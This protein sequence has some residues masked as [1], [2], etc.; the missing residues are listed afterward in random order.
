M[1]LI[2]NPSCNDSTLVPYVPTSQNPWDISK[3]NHVYRRLGF[4]AIQSDIDAALGLTPD[5]FIDNLVDTAISL[6]VTAEPFWGHFSVNDFVDFE[7]ENNQYI[8]E[9]RIQTGNDIIDHGL[10]GKLAFFWMNHFVTELEAYNYSPYMYQYY[11]LMQTYALGNI[12]DFTEAIGINPAMLIYLNGFEN[13]NINPNENYARELYELFTLGE[14]IGYTQ[15][16][17]LETA[18]ALTGYN[19]W[20]EVG[21]EIYFDA[22]TFDAGVKTI[23]G[24]TGSWGYSD[25]IHILFQER[26]TEIARHFCTKLYTFFVSPSVDAIIETNVIQP[27]AQTLINNNFELVPILKQLFKSEHFFDER[28]RGV[29]IKSPYDLMFS[30]SKETGF[31][32]NDDIMDAFV[33]YGALMGQ[34]MYNPL[35]VAGWQRDESWIN[36]STLTGR[37]QLLELYLSYLYESGYEFTLVDLAR[38]LSN[39]SIDPYYITQ[40]MIDRFMSKALYTIED[41]NIA[42]DIFKWDIPQNYYDEGLWN[43]SWSTAP[44]QC[45]LLLKHI[46]TIPEFQLK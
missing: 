22:S 35:D 33:Y 3:V 30:F 31:F 45:F 2:A 42:T 17:I 44:Y 15:D 1:T 12:K 34:E 24:Q 38:D 16:D 20:I 13:T 39:D 4:G 18:R 6:P 7:T 19:H 8:M 23:F 28:A 5:E 14:G 26:A 46:A 10:R 43:L 36:T 27:L 25:V 29:V 21:G 37:W 9:W 11:N 40:V 41:Y 32:Y